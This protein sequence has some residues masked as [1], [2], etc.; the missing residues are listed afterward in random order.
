MHDAKA[1]CRPICV[2]DTTNN[3]IT[4][5]YDGS[6][7]NGVHVN[8]AGDVGIGTTGPTSTLEVNGD[9]EIETN[10]KF[11]LSKTSNACILFNGTDIVLA[12]NLTGVT[13]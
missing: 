7:V 13:C 12:N 3:V 4:L 8:N 2:K 10:D 5:N 9:I 11:I 1:L 6:L